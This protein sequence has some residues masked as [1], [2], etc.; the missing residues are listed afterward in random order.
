MSE[1]PRIPRRLREQVLSFYGAVCIVTGEP[2]SG[3][4][5]HHLDENNAN[6]RFENLI[7]LAATLNNAIERYRSQ[8]NVADGRLRSEAL[9]LQA[10]KKYNAGQFQHSYACNRLASFLCT[11]WYGQADRAMSHAS[12]ALLA[13]RAID[14]VPL[15]DDT[16]RRTVLS[17]LDRDGSKPSDRINPDSKASLALEISLYFRDYGLL[18]E[19]GKWLD[20]SQR[21]LED[22]EITSNIG[23]RQ[24]IEFR[25]FQHRANLKVARGDRS[26]ELDWTRKADDKGARYVHEFGSTNN[27]LW[28]GHFLRQDGR[29]DDALELIKGAEKQYG[30][31]FVESV[32]G[33]VGHVPAK[34][35][36]WT[37][38][39]LKLLYADICE[40]KGGNRDREMASEL[41]RDAMETFLVYR[42]TP[43]ITY[44]SQRLDSKV[45]RKRTPVQLLEMGH[46][47]REVW[48]K[49][50][51]TC[52]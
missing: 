30:S 29:L 4:D 46:T 28:R 51:T 20:L 40:A 12:R 18:D 26:A 34:Y 3:N 31:I 7:P 11:S 36:H 13:L 49:L 37:Y 9:D 48:D 50:R 15:A 39:Q 6:H 35:N 19:A 44:P 42:I 38:A 52:A 8:K 45:I 10:R 33:S 22:S 47:C 27:V 43:T 17:L 2:S 25:I 1:R 21:F 5:L 14:C 41:T 32:A 24:E 23:L 16:L